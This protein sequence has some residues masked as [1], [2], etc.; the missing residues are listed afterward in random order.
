MAVFPFF[1][2]EISLF[3]LQKLWNF[4]FFFHDFFWNLTPVLCTFFNFFLQKIYQLY[5]IYSSTLKL[6]TKW[7]IMELHKSQF[8]I[9]KN[10]LHKLQFSFW[11]FPSSVKF[12]LF[13]KKF[14][15]FLFQPYFRCGLRSWDTSWYETS[16]TIHIPTLNLYFIL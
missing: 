9:K 1:E 14:S 13:E 4:P 6:D 7:L 5:Q 11:F 16:L 3:S 15:Q 2:L 12:P 8:F 10:F